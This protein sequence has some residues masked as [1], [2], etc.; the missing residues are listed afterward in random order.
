V[1][2][3]VEE[4]VLSEAGGRS[5]DEVQVAAEKACGVSNNESNQQREEGEKIEITAVLVHTRRATGGAQ[6]E[7]RRKTIAVVVGRWG[8]WTRRL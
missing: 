1:Q 7:G 4:D 6:R 2:K 3:V 5:I 8:W